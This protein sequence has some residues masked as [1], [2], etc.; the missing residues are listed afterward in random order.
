MLHVIGTPE[1]ARIT[2]A[3]NTT[4]LLPV[5][6]FGGVCFWFWRAGSSVYGLGTLDDAII[7]HAFKSKFLFIAL[8][9]HLGDHVRFRV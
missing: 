3:L 1:D 8:Y 7:P 4:I 2:N 5:C 9:Q 6:L